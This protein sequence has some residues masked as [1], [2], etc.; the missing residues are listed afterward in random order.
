MEI[1]V[2]NLI[3][4][5]DAKTLLDEMFN[6]FTATFTRLP[7]NVKQ[8]MKEENG[9]VVFL[10]MISTDL[11]GHALKPYTRPYREL[12]RLI[13]NTVAKV[14]KFLEE[15]FNN[16]GRT[17]YLFTADHGMTDWGAHGG[18]HVTETLTPVIAWGAG[19]SGP[20]AKLTNL[21][22]IDLCPLMSGILG[23]PVPT[24]NRGRLLPNMLKLTSKDA[25][26]LMQANVRQL[27]QVFELTK[28]KTRKA[29]MFLFFKDFDKL[30]MESANKRLMLAEKALK[31]RVLL[32][33]DLIN[34]RL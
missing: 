17:A 23:L 12:M 30:T 8:R 14:E 18:G 3:T 9:L 29:S 16:D 6:N 26:I 19:V 15:Y 20:L 33:A 10:H 31:V 7:A 21:Q 5:D 4:G 25:A 28:Q 34:A 11:G 22:Q 2:N 24:N 32:F 1:F 13:D 27:L